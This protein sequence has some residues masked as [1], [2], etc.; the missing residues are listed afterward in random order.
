VPNEGKTY[1]L[2]LKGGHVIDPANGVDAVRDVAIREGRIARVA[3]GIPSSQAEKVV[4]VA[5]CCVTP[6]LLDIHV[7]VFGYA[8]WLF[9]DT[10]AFPNGVTTVVDTGG[11]GH[12]NFEEFRETVLPQARTRVFA[13]LNIVGAGMLGAVEQD[14]GEMKPVPAAEMI[15]KY[16]DV[17]IGSKTA[18]FQGPGWEAVDGAV[19][20]AALSGT[21]AMIDFAPKP[22]RSYK[23]LLLQRLRPGDIHTHLYAK[24]I[25]LLDE[26]RRVNGYVREARE[27]GVLFDLGHGAGSFWFRIAVPAM[28]QGFGPDSISTDLHKSSAL[29]PNATMPVTMSKMLNIGM[30][31][32]EVI[33]RSTAEPA[34]MI[35]RPELGTLSVGAEA[36]VAAFRIEEGAFGFVD[37][38]HAKMRGTRR[39][40]CVLTV[41]AGQIVWDLDG[42]SWPDWETAGNYDV[43]R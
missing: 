36:D 30:P 9:P 31:L 23:E 2:L 4:D 28:K 20:A 19:E 35:R 11:A 40:Q 24:H 42:L 41:R 10:H 3:E 1:S 21:F 38:G 29:I 18:H 25:P 26:D 17:L 32:Q 12:K 8:G 33:L 34:R 39:L 22:A 15:R 5:G 14:V 13:L 43:I 6:G 16:P 7:H 27:R 37:S